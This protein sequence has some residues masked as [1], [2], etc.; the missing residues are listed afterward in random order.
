VSHGA[1][2][3]AAGAV[4]RDGAWGADELEDG[5]GYAMVIEG[6]DAAWSAFALTEDDTFVFYSLSPVDARGERMGP[7]AE[8][9]HRANH[10]LLTG[11]FE[12]DFDTGEIRL[13]TGIELLTLAP[14]L[15]KDDEA[16]E[17]VVL[18]LSAANVGLFDRYLS[19]LLAV[20]VG[21]ADAAAVVREIESDGVPPGA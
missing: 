11:A 8:F 18:D 17:A 20:A 9:L 10:G 1:L 19:G 15:L 16:L 13:R 6:T 5:A 14:D 3:R 2:H 7:V 21:R 4:F 12:L